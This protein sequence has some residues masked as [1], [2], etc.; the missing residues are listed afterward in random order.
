MKIKLN[1]RRFQRILKWGGAAI[2]LLVLLACWCT[3]NTCLTWTSLGRFH[4]VELYSGSIRWLHW[5]DHVPYS[6]VARAN[7][8]P[9]GFRT[10]YIHDGRWHVFVLPYRE[11]VRTNTRTLIP[12]WLPLVIVAMPTAS[13]FWL[14]RRRRIPPGHCQRCGYNLTGNISGICSECGEPCKAE[15]SAT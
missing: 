14:D 11:T 13:L 8:F 3:W 10:D 9:P 7:S 6:T 4:R 5:H 15:A 2:C 1:P 12:L